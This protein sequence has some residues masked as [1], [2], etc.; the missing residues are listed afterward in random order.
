[1]ACIH[2]EQLVACVRHERPQRLTYIN[3]IWRNNPTWGLESLINKN[4]SI[5]QLK[6]IYIAL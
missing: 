2:I 6:H 4:R 3:Q 5:N 1:V